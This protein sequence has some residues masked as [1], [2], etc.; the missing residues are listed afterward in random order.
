MKRAMRMHEQNEAFFS[1][2]RSHIRFILDNT[3]E[4]RNPYFRQHGKRAAFLV[5]AGDKGL[6]GNYNSEILKLAQSTIKENDFTQRTIFTIGHIASE[7]F[8]KLRMDPDVDYIHVVQDPSLHHAREITYE[9][10]TQFRQKYLDEVYVIY[11]VL[12]KNGSL[13]PTVLRL[14]P[15]LKQDFTDV[16]I[17]HKPIGNL[18]YHPSADEVLESLVPH[19]LI[20]LLYSALVQS[21]ASEH[22]ARM[23]AMDNATRNADEMLSRLKL[24]LNHAR[25]SLI[26]REL[27]EIIS[28]SENLGQGDN[29]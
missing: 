2:V 15:V 20:G 3:R 24:L 27:A 13:S 26:T 23:T 22:R 14:L 11:T 4:I 9:L 7:H 21:F 16:Q 5:I 8:M 19:Y 25:Q 28:G 18:V 17:L 1:H 10:C 12:E 6:C 29:V